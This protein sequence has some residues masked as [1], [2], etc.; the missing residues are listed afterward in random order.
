MAPGRLRRGR[1]AYSIYSLY[2]PKTSPRGSRK[3]YSCHEPY[4]LSL[5]RGIGTASGTPCAACGMQGAGAV[6]PRTRELEVRPVN[7]PKAKHRPPRR[8]PAV[9]VGLGPG[10]ATA[11]DPQYTNHGCP[12]KFPL[13]RE[14]TQ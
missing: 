1:C 9:P 3:S 13:K 2:Q 14:R 6:A 11:R 10:G 8:P 7:R 5:Y 4:R 12:R